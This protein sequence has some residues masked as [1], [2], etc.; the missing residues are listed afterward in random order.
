MREEGYADRERGDGSEAG[1]Y[2]RFI[3]F[4]LLEGRR[5][6][7]ADGGQ[8]GQVAQPRRWSWIQRLAHA[9]ARLRERGVG[10]ERR[11]ARL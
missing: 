4:G 5:V 1:S 6:Q 2:L 3:D 9:R 7:A 11:W 8:Q 10:E